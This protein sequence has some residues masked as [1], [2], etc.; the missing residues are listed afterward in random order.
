V[1]KLAGEIPSQVCFICRE[2]FATSFQKPDLPLLIAVPRGEKGKYLLIFVCECLCGDGRDDFSLEEDLGVS[3]CREKEN[4][5]MIATNFSAVY[6][7]CEITSG[8][9]TTSL[10][11]SLISVDASQPKSEMDVSRER[12]F[13][14]VTGGAV[15]DGGGGWWCGWKRVC[16]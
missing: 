16:P 10:Q 14:V 15:P 13:R 9:C 7:A 8:T 5:T 12:V 6:A 3:T 11:T 4:F 1:I 2:D